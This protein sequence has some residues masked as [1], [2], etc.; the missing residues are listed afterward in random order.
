MRKACW[1]GAGLFA[2]FA[3]VQINDPDPLRWI[4][5]YG[6]TAVYSGFAG[7]GKLSRGPAVLWAVLMGFSGVV[8]LASTNAD[9]PMGAAWMGVFASES[10]REG[11]GLLLA[12]VWSA[13][14]AWL[15]PSQKVE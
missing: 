4:V 3:A 13:W 15:G 7:L 8:T 6:L 9:D 5:I 11:G 1:F 12:A 14:L 2:L 10:V